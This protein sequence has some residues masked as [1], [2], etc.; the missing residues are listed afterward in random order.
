[1]RSTVFSAIMVILAALPFSNKNM[2]WAQAPKQPDSA[3]TQF[4]EV[5]LFGSETRMLHSDIVNE[6]FEIYISYPLG[7]PA[8]DT[9]YPVLYCLDANRSF[10]LVSNVVNILSMPYQ[11][12]PY[13]LVVGIGYPIESMADWGAW[14]R[15]DLTPTHD[16]TSDKNWTDF[17]AE[18]SGRDD[19]VVRSGGGPK[20]LEFIRQELIPFIEANYP[21]S[22]TDRSLVGFSLS[23]LF[24]LYALLESP[25]TF[26]RYLAGS[27]SIT[28]DNNVLF[29]YERKFAEN[30]SDLAA[31]VFMSIGTLENEANIANV[32]KLTELLHSRNYPNLELE[33]RIFDNETHSSGVA[34]AI[35][36]GL[37][38]IFNDR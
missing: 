17:L 24:S 2:V 34:G 15:R 5:T 22:S 35:S 26:K 8:S 28:W 36:R 1:M 23:G 7:P 32:N 19:I 3:I 29:Q 31:R 33:T 11:E 27:P 10:G 37:L 20:F 4:P 25:G 30:N 38:V 13:M 14:R 16:S 6:D 21:V 9:V 18:L 12:I